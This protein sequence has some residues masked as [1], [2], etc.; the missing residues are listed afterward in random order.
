MISSRWSAARVAKLWLEVSMGLIALACVMMILWLLLLAAG[1]GH[2]DLVDLTVMVS[3]GDSSIL[4][5][6]PLRLDSSAEEARPAF[7]GARLVKG[8]GELR[9]MTSDRSL[10]LAMVIGYMGALMVTL[11][12]LWK[13]RLILVSTIAGDPFRRINASRL[14]TMGL[15]LIGLALAWPVYQ[16]LLA[17]KVLPRVG[18][19]DLALAPQLQP[20]MDPLLV[21]VLLLVLSTV[22]SHGTSL[23]DERSLT[24]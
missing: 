19:Q 23:E 21:G 11:L 2:D 12:I 3:I 18:V 5:V 16:Y 24:V 14:R 20:P 8:S 10:H 4:P 15:A 1:L 22:F 7:D 6:V 13:L 17:A 9:V